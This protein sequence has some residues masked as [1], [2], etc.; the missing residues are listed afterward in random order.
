MYTSISPNRIVKRIHDVHMN[1]YDIQMNED[2]LN[3][4][5]T[6]LVLDCPLHG[7]WETSFTKTVYDKSGCPKCVTLRSAITRKTGDPEATRVEM[8]KF[9][10]YV[11]KN[12]SR[13]KH[14]PRFGNHEMLLKIYAQFK[15]THFV[16]KHNTEGIKH[17]S[18]YTKPEALKRIRD[19][20][21]N[22]FEFPYFDDEFQ[23]TNSPIT[24][25]CII[26]GEFKTT[27]NRLTSG[28]CGCP[29][30]SALR[31]G[32]ARKYGVEEALRMMI[33]KYARIRKNKMRKR[34]GKKIVIDE[35]PVENVTPPTKVKTEKK[36]ASPEERSKD[37][38][39]NFSDIPK[40]LV[41]KLHPQL[42]NIYTLWENSFEFPNFD[43]EYFNDNSPLTAEC[44]I[45]GRFVTSI[46]KV[47]ACEAGVC[48][49][50]ESLFTNY[51]KKRG[52]CKAI[53]KM[54]EYYRTIRAKKSLALPTSQKLIVEKSQA[55]VSPALRDTARFLTKSKQKS[56]MKIFDI[57]KKNDD[58]LINGN[59]P[60]LSVAMIIEKP[61]E[62]QVSPPTPNENVVSFSVLSEEVLLTIEN[63]EE[64]QVVN[65][66]VIQPTVDDVTQNVDVSFQPAYSAEQGCCSYF[67]QLIAQATIK[68]AEAPP[69]NLDTKIDEI[70]EE[71]API[72]LEPV[73]ASTT[74]KK[75]EHVIVKVK[76]IDDY[77][78]TF[79]C[80]EIPTTISGNL[81][82]KQVG[83]GEV[84]I[85]IMQVRRWNVAAN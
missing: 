66:P 8:D 67:D 30:C 5:N 42:R 74:E 78:E 3:G 75:S 52:K 11:R 58:R 57:S 69:S 80:L 39:T 21:K 43:K 19:V 20:H 1:S 60:P 76:W 31:G 12:I 70:G 13:I 77:S 51:R 26:H 35:Q 71:L 27:F 56:T 23:I 82:I 25:V 22:S 7:S 24:A 62:V 73:N 61:V 15:G 63:P 37:V 72:K 33:V 45:H 40:L 55:N 28:K 17:K 79:K 64:L 65:E 54:I 10:E 41:A 46:S 81:H 2:E 53:K 36:K 85:P 6:P 32:L 38:V 4:V 44:I 49:H 34:F 83:G 84:N 47:I 59:K 50:C 14:Y 48:P 9:Y 29:E 16:P 18:I 68:S